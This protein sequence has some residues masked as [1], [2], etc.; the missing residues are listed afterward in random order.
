[1]NEKAHDYN[2]IHLGIGDTCYTGLG[3]EGTIIALRDAGYD[4]LIVTL[5]T[6]SQEEIDADVFLNPEDVEFEMIEDYIPT[7]ENFHRQHKGRLAEVGDLVKITHQNH[8]NYNHHAR[9]Q[10]IGK[11]RWN[12]GYTLNDESIS[13]KI[14]SLL[15][16]YGSKF[17]RELIEQFQDEPTL[18]RFMM[19]KR[20]EKSIHLQEEDLEDNYRNLKIT[21]MK[22]KRQFDQAVEDIGS[23][24]QRLSFLAQRNEFEIV[25]KKE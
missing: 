1:M 8:D 10:S 5:D 20:A 3:I 19:R 18:R 22:N 12:V 23:L 7:P 17:R 16:S 25:Q 21:E 24:M 11:K 14:S 6:R 15:Q 2:R 9:I 13:Y 4:R